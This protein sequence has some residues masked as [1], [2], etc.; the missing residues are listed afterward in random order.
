[1][2]G[3]LLIRKYK[4]ENC[5][6][7]RRSR[8][9]IVNAGQA[10]WISKWRSMEHWKVLSAIMVGGQE[11]FSNSR[12]SRTAKT[13]IFWPWWQPF[14]SFCFETLSFLPL[15]AFF[16]FATQKSGGGHGAL[17]RPGVAGPK[18]L[19]IQRLWHGS[20]ELFPR[21]SLGK[22]KRTSY[23]AE[24]WGIWNQFYTRKS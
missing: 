14:N 22:I 18:M 1:M 20:I 10:K 8:T 9:K 13:I 7:K 19:M 6:S 2:I 16:L 11:K 17:G 24:T 5:Q 15:S 4:S 3:F 12:R 23:I 21:F